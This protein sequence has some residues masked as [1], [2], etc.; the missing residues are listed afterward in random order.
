MNA[1][2]ALSECFDMTTDRDAG[3]REGIEAE[4]LP[5]PFCGGGAVIEQKGTTR[6]SNI[7]ACIECG[8]RLESGDV[9]DSTKSWNI[10]ALLPSTPDDAKAE[11]VAVKLLDWGPERI[12]G[13]FGV[14]AQ[15]A[16]TTIGTYV[17][18]D[19]GWFLNGQSGW[20]SCVSREAAKAGAQDDYEHRI[21]SAI[22]HPCPAS[23]GAIREAF[24]EIANRA[25]NMGD[26]DAADWLPS[27]YRIACEASGE[28]P[29]PLLKRAGYDKP[30]SAH[31]GDAAKESGGDPDLQG[32]EHCGKS[33]DIEQMTMMEDHWIC[34]TCYAAWKTTFDAC[35]HS[36]ESHVGTS[37]D[38][39]RYCSKCCGFEPGPPDTHAES[40]P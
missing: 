17:A 24:Y 4:L 25:S 18:S 8:C 26:P 5:C 31:A 16:S 23:D 9:F 33:F 38:S 14:M 32:C 7:V 2:A 12:T 27:I 13:E 34:P 37:G 1:M 19:N 11:A 36:W 10:R 39:G 29:W 20:N 30:L 35:E 15:D 3:Y 40:K 21:R 6:Q 28:D 22:V